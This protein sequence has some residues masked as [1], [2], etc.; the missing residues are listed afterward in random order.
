[1]EELSE[2]SAKWFWQGFVTGPTGA[3]QG[4]VL[5]GWVAAPLLHIY[6]P[7]DSR[8]QRL[9]NYIDDNA[10]TNQ[11]LAPI[12]HEVDTAAKTHFFC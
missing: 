2:T 7:A 5:V 3:L 8:S 12:G 1:M 4:C 11:L 6:F 10:L 9:N